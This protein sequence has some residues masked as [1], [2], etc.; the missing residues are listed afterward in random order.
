M[1]YQQ[2]PYKWPPR[3]FACNITLQIYSDNHIKTVLTSSK[4]L[5]IYNTKALKVSR[6][7]SHNFLSNI[8]PSPTPT[9]STPCPTNTHPTNGR[10]ARSPCNITIQIY[11]DNHIKTVLKNSLTNL[12]SRSYIQHKSFKGVP[13]SLP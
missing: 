1:P 8:R 2:T 4:H 5:L 3:S 11:S 9:H 10:R 13:K 6:K 7:V 12:K